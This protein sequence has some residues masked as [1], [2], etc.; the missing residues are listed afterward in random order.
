M[1]NRKCVESPIPNHLVLH[2]VYNNMFGEF[3]TRTLVGLNELARSQTDDFEDFVQQTQLYLHKYDKN[4]MPMLDSHHLFTDAFR[5]YPLLDFKSLLHNTGCQCLRRLILCGYKEEDDD[6]GKKIITPNDGLQIHAAE[7]NPK[8]FQDLRQTIRR[9]RV[10]LDNPLVQQEIEV[11]REEVLRAK[12]IKP[13]FHDW[14]LIGLTQRTGRRRWLNLD[15][16]LGDCEKSLEELQHCVYR[17]ERGEQGV[18]SLST[19]GHAQ[20]SRRLDWNLWCT[21]H[22]SNLDETGIACRRDIAVAVFKID[23]GSLDRR[24]QR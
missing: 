20:C 22:G 14:K 16:N 17:S 9:R 6:N 12:G 18:A 11:Y 24:S 7:N 15:N 5:A 13:P 8:L 10:I 23:D 19:G 1:S 3:Y 4:D 21:A 2:S